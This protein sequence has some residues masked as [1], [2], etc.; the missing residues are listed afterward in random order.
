MA[1]RN[2]QL[3]CSRL[4]RLVCLPC[5]PSPAGLGQRLLHHWRGIDE[6]LDVGVARLGDQP[7]RQRLQR[8]FDDIVIIA[9][10]GIDRD[11][12]DLPLPGQRKR[13]GGGG[14][15]SCP[16]RSRC[17]PRATRQPGSRGDARAPPSRSCRRAGPRPAIAAAARPCAARRR[18]ARPRTQRS[19]APQPSRSAA[20][21]MTCLRP[22]SPATT[23]RVK[24][25]PFP[26]VILSK[27]VNEPLVC[28]APTPCGAIG[29]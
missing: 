14:R 15:N 12:A 2:S 22:S 26:F 23:A 27:P 3:P 28:A 4:T 7:P 21:S 17:A 13:I 8:P 9:A 18:H 11:P 20:P 24:S 16:A 6:H 19:R 5:H 25:E 29:R 1:P 10:L